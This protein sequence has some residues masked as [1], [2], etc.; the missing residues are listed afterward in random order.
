MTFPDAAKLPA[1]LSVYTALWA[2]STQLEHIKGPLG[3]PLRPWTVALLL[4]CAAAAVMPHNK[5]LA[6]LAFSMRCVWWMNRWPFMWAS[7]I[8]GG[9]TDVAVV[10]HL[11]AASNEE[12]LTAGLSLSIRRQVAW[13][14]FFAG[15]WK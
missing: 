14:Y 7:E 12:H 3:G 10:L 4:L 5:R 13:F 1:P 6:V 15:F 8:I 9:L 2:L 11:V